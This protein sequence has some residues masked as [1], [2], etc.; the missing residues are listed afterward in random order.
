MSRPD[1]AYPLYDARYE[2]DACGVGFVA[3]AGARSRDR[4]LGLAL[5][6]LSNLGHRGAFA[7]DGESSDGAG[8]AL[9]LEA[10]LAAHLG[11]DVGPGLRLRG[12]PGLLM[13]FLPA[14]PAAA[15]RARAIVEAALQAER[16]TIAAWRDV[17]V[18]ASALGVEARGSLPLV[19]QAFVAAP[20]GSRLAFE[21]RLLLARR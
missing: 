18:D 16:L 9:P 14:A 2:H 11:R 6:G 17:P 4:V 10:A 20:G 21:R 3:D 1:S 12:R 8:I 19:A 5:A 15:S 13:L 7:A